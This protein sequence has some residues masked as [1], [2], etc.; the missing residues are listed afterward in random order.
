MSLAAASPTARIAR[1]IGAL[2]DALTGCACLVVWVA[3]LALGQG[4][5]KTVVL[6][7][8]MEFLLVHGTG[9]F[10]AIVFADGMSKAKRLLMMAGLLC[11]YGLFVAAF[12]FAFEAWWPV[13]M[14]LW[15]VLSKAAWVFLSG[16]DRVQEAQR[17]LQAWAFS[18]A[19]YICA[20]FAGLLLPLPRLGLTEAAVAQLGLPG[21]G[22]WVERPHTAVAG[23]ALYYFANAWFKWFMERPRAAK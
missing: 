10:T 4:A 23:M 9:F 12:C 14:F 19:A 20:V 22:E 11:F 13:W 3:P 2:P 17:Q 15:L 21:S 18:T 5:V 7:M 1:L 8:L 16:R 6:M